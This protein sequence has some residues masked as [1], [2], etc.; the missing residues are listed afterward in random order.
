MKPNEFWNCT[1]IEALLYVDSNSL[2][3]ENNK[4]DNIVLLEQYG[5][6]IIEAFSWKKPKNR[7]LIKDIFKELFEEELNYRNEMSV[8]EMQRNMRKWNDD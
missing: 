6:K 3:R 8:E 2:Q 1:Y 5:N 7:S 4:K